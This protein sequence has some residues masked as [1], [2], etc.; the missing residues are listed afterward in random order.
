MD[1]ATMV[2]IPMAS[3]MAV[4]VGSAIVAGAV[5]GAAGYVAKGAMGF[6]MGQAVAQAASTPTEDN[7]HMEVD[8]RYDE[9]KHDV[10]D[11]D[12]EMPLL[13]DSEEWPALV[14]PATAQPVSQAPAAVMGPQEELPGRAPAVMGPQ[15]QSIAQAPVAPAPVT[16]APAT[17]AP[18][19]SAVLPPVSAFDTYVRQTISDT[20]LIARL[21][22]KRGP[23]LPPLTE[24]T[25]ERCQETIDELAYRFRVNL[26]PQSI[27]ARR[28]AIAEYEINKEK[29]ETD[30][31]VA[32]EMTETDQYCL[33][34]RAKVRGNKK[35]WVVPTRDTKRKREE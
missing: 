5:S 28:K 12:E 16:Q 2:G 22:P 27:S 19:A 10:F 26:S 29:L 17:P 13:E 11:F 34:L 3:A 7:N 8:T 18:Q 35:L 23:S 15:E 25:Q 21:Q 31:K 9:V 1:L 30:Y 4:G 6:L 20:D 33:A 14:Y 32:V 24:M